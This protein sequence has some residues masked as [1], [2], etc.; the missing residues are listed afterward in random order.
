VDQALLLRG[1]RDFADREQY[2]RFIE[3]LTDKR[4]ASRRAKLAE[5]EACI[6][7]L[8]SDKLDYRHRVTGIRVPGRLVRR[9]LLSASATITP[10]T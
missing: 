1:S 9:Q 7:E 10:V 6:G 4:N 2:E 3:Q 8:P 5:E